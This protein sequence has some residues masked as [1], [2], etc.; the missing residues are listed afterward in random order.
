[1]AFNIAFMLSSDQV[2]HFDNL[3]LLQQ[4]RTVRSN[5]DRFLWVVMRYGLQIQLCCLI[6]AAKDWT[7]CTPAL[8]WNKLFLQTFRLNPFWHLY[9]TN[10]INDHEKKPHTSVLLCMQCNEVQHCSHF[11][12]SDNSYWSMI[13]TVRYEVWWLTYVWCPLYNLQINGLLVKRNTMVTTHGP[14][15][16]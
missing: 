15:G 12:L 14:S 10:T 1:M 2:L 13:G 11:Q 4:H 8:Q 7:Q 6:K 5:L 16:Y 9:S 3:Y